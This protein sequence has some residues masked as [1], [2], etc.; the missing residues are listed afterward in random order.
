MGPMQLVENGPW[1]HMSLTGGLIQ[2][3]PQHHP[4][5][6]SASNLKHYP[7][8]LMMEFNCMDLLLHQT[9]EIVEVG[10]GGTNWPIT[11][12]SYQMVLVHTVVAHRTSLRHN[13]GLHQLSKKSTLM[14]LVLQEGVS[15][16]ILQ[17]LFL[18]IMNFQG[19]L[20][21]F[22][23]LTFMYYLL[24]PLLASFMLTK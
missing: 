23:S 24:S 11:N 19:C 3:S 6:I 2:A 4:D 15:I 8:A 20:V 21:G 16:L 18:Y 12:M 14:I 10:W 17:L 22:R 13:S 1:G 5:G 7:L 9:V